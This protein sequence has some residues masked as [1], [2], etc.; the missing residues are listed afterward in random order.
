MDQ[1]SN[2]PRDAVSRYRW[3]RI[4]HVNDACA[5][6]G[7]FS[8]VEWVRWCSSVSDVFLE[9]FAVGLNRETGRVVEAMQDSFADQL[10]LDDSGLIFSGADSF[11]TSPNNKQAKCFY[12]CT[13][14]KSFEL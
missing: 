3:G 9:H 7:L 6:G 11:R 5:Y 2:D 12:C 10:F 13:F 8:G 4:F 14:T 1:N